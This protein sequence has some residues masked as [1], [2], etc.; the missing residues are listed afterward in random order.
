MIRLDA[1]GV[2]QFYSKREAQLS[3]HGAR[4][5][6][7]LDFFADSE[8]NHIGDF[9][10]RD[11]EICVWLRILPRPMREKTE[12]AASIHARTDAPGVQRGFPSRGNG[13]DQIAGAPP[14]SRYDQFPPV[15]QGLQLLGEVLNGQ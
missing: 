8:F 6:V 15:I 10:D 2:T 11:R 1:G 13:D 7:G 3:G 9:A 5:A 12:W 4:P 14:P